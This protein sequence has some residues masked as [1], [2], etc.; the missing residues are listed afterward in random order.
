MEFVRRHQPDAWPDFSDSGVLN[1]LEEWLAPFASGATGLAQIRKIDLH[2]ALSSLLTHRQKMELARLAPERI[3]V[4]SGSMIRVDYSS[5]DGVPFME[6]RLQEMFGMLDTPRVVDGR[7]PVTIRM[8]SPAMRPVQTTSDLRHFWT[9]SYFLVRKDLRG[10]YPKHDWPENPLEAKA[11]RG[12]R[13]P[14]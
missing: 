10:R 2:T 8:L 4:P 1:S 14:K 3:E 12:V 9:E 13:K 11:H 5:P 7:V 6:V